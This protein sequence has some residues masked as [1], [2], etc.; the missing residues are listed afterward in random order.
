MGGR[1]I[2]LPIDGSIIQ[3]YVDGTW[4]LRAMGPR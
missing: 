1:K 3:P 4:L 2:P